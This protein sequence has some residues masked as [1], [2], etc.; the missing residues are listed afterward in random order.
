VRGRPS[1]KTD[2]YNI[3]HTGMEK[4]KKDFSVFKVGHGHLTCVLFVYLVNDAASVTDEMVCSHSTEGNCCDVIRPII[5]AMN[6]L[7]FG[8]VQSIALLNN[9]LIKVMNKC[10]C[11]GYSA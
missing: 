10:H 11:T 7:L 8:C 3:T 1:F 9:S 5:L 2:T 4:V 6:I